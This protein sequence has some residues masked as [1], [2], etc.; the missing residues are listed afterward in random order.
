MSIDRIKGNVTF[1]CDLRGC[2]N[3]LE[4]ATGDFAEA[5]DEAK[6][7]G[8]QFRNRDGEWKHFCCRTHEEMDF[9]GQSIT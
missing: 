3:D 1:L 9:R 7:E 8:W 5:K 2:D 6:Q 4:T